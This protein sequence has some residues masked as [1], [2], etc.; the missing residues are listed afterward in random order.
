M[1]QYKSD[2][3]N[4]VAERGF[5]HQC[6]NF[7]GL[8]ALLASGPQS[9]YCGYDPTGKSLHV[10]HL[11]SI[12]MLH[13]FQQ[14]GNKPY[15]LVGGATAMI[16][17]PSFKDKTR[18]LLT[19]DEI[20]ANIESIKQSYSRFIRYG[21]GPIDASMVNNADWILGLNYMEFLRDYGTCFT[22]N[23]MMSFD[24]VKAQLDG[25]K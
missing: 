21:N 13:W 14:T 22:I 11:V 25:I 19:K 23:R 5:I 10:G 6:S 3:L 1:T 2:F 9:A 12:M 8:D 7:E 15:T 16:G 17:D 24:S 4:I 20:N 18:P